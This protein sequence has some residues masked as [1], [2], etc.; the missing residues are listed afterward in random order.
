MSN[1]GELLSCVNCEEFFERRSSKG[2]VPRF[3]S[4][5]CMKRA[6][7]L[8]H[9]DECKKRARRWA[10]L[11][12][13]QRQKVLISFAE[14]HPEYQKEVYQ[15][16]IEQHGKVHFRAVQ[17]KHRST[18][19]WRENH[20]IR[21]AERRARLRGTNGSV[22][23]EEFS[24]V[25]MGVGNKCL[26]CGISFTDDERPTIDHV[27]PISKGGVHLIENIQPLCFACNSAKGTTTM[28]YR[29]QEANFAQP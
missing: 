11:N 9:A 21:Q 22:S 25:V 2:P 15:R 24:N 29:T 1:T 20:R 18:E 6:Y 8:A 17:K 3:C 19:L 13:Q 16:R 14:R 7:Y 28:D 5:P 26:R 4:T 27:I 10:Q 23:K 12:P